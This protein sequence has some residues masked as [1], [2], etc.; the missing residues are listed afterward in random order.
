MGLLSHRDF[1]RKS[2]EV[3]I[4]RHRSLPVDKE[5]HK[6]VSELC[7][8]SNPAPLWNTRTIYP[9]RSGQI[10][11]EK[12]MSIYGTSG[13]SFTVEVTQSSPEIALNKPKTVKVGSAD[14]M[15]FQFNPPKGISKRQLDISVT[16]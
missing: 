1:F 8:Y 2:E 4:E 15:V 14:V 7:K 16:S 11:G 12:Y 10:S 6:G 9:P 5:T 13:V 3:A